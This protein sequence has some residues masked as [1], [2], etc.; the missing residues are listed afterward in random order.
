M[1]VEHLHKEDAESSCHGKPR[2]LEH[3]VLRLPLRC[4]S[5]IVADRYKKILVSAPCCILDVDPRFVQ[6]SATV[7]AMTLHCAHVPPTLP[8]PEHCLLALKRCV[9]EVPF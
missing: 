1:D 6:A 5:Q 7:Q 4:L 8:M 3:V 2:E 9:K